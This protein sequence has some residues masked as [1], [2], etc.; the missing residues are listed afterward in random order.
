M[1]AVDDY[2]AGHFTPD[3]VI[4]RVQRE[5]ILMLGGGRAFLMQASHPR[6]LA[7]F[8][9]H[10][11]YEDDPFDRLWRTMATVWTSVFGSPE[12]ADAAGR[13]VRAIHK[14]VCGTLTEQA[15][16]FP[17]D[18]PYAADD[19]D[20]LLWVQATLYETSLLMY[21][22]FV[23][24]LNDDENDQLYAQMWGAARV[25]GLPREVIPDD[26]H[27]FREYMDG[28]LASETI[29][30]GNLARRMGA[31]IIDPP[32]PRAARSAWPLMNFT[33]TALLT[34]KLREGFSL[35]WSPA[36]ERLFQTSV[37]AMRRAVIPLL[38]GRARIL[39]V[40]RAAEKR[41][42]IARGDRPTTLA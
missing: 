22:T 3:D 2:R 37:P 25:W 30:V 7:G 1:H 29:T 16:P 15:G 27:A 35:S 41:H 20:L 24:P 38:P 28:M 8:E 18:T 40:A 13:K 32:L 21:E 23:R 6:A 26:R 12:E 19:P 11:D 14:R 39:P 9:Q 4:W 31:V 36:R 17:I 34:P 42:A 5:A 33:T 10:S